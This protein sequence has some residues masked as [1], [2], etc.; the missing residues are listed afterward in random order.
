MQGTCLFAQRTGLVIPHDY[1]DMKEAIFFEKDLS[2]AV[3]K[4]KWAMANKEKLPEIA[5]AGYNKTIQYHTSLARARYICKTMG[6]RY[7]D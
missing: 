4:F 3:S 6:I 2:D 5:K 1:E 7:T